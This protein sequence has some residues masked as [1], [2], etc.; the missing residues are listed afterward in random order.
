MMPPTTATTPTKPAAQQLPGLRAWIALGGASFAALLLFSTLLISLRLEKALTDLVQNRAE[1]MAQQL[2]DS[3]EGGLRL[4]V[5]LEDQ[6]ETPRKMAALSDRDPELLHIAL[7]DAQSKNW[8][9]TSAPRAAPEVRDPT[10]ALRHLARKSALGVDGTHKVWVDGQGVQ[11]LTQVRDATG[12]VSGAVWVVYSTQ[13][14]QAAFTH[15]MRQLGLWALAMTVGFF[16]VLAVG[17]TQVA[18]RSLRALDRLG[19]VDSGAGASPWPWLPLPQALQT[20]DR[21]ETELASLSAHGP[22]GGQA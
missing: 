22:H 21:L 12:L 13:A 11:V 7:L 4:G 17:L 6:T 1:L 20:L 15:S 18:R 8:V 9:Q 5:R 19:G 10:A 16:A 14:P 2:A 3:V